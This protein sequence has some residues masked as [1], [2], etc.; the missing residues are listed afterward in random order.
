MTGAEDISEPGYDWDFLSQSE[1]EAVETLIEQNRDSSWAAQLFDKLAR[2]GGVRRENKATMFELRFAAAVARA[3]IEL[4]YEVPG[5]GESTIDFGFEA[6]GVSWAVELMRLDETDAAKA[7]TVTARDE[8]GAVWSQRI[9]SD[10]REDKRQ[11]EGGETLKAIQ[12]ICQKCELDGRPHK[13]KS[14]HEAFNI[15]LVDVRTLFN[16]GDKADR[17]HIALGAMAVPGCFRQQFRGNPVTGVFDEATTLKGAKEARE[18]IHFIGFVEEREFGP[19]A[20][21]PSIQ[22]VANPYLFN[23]EE[24]ARAAIGAWPLKPAAVL[25]LRGEHSGGKA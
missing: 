15:L 18:R 21:G 9:L 20:F 11:T 19:D 1:G 12:R 10:T 4:Q 17:L 25:N 7:A 6:G 16:G 8:E 5:E 22:F 23:D 3:G 2:A 13:F 24:S 14:P